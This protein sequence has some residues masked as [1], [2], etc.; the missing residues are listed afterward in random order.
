MEWVSVYLQHCVVGELLSKALPKDLN[1][2][3]LQGW[4]KSVRKHRDIVF[5]HIS[6]GTTIQPLQIV[7]SP[8]DLPK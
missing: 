3:T 4:V 1:K 7:L 5:L 2:F 6:D 8:Q